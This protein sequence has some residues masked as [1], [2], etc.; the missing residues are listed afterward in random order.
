VLQPDEALIEAA[1][2]PTPF[3]RKKVMS[4]AMTSIAERARDMGCRR[5]L[6]VIGANNEPSLRGARASGFERRLFRARA[7]TSP[8]D[9]DNR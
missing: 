9:V 7:R 5:V 1:F 2:T 4:A 8:L 6:T 3:R